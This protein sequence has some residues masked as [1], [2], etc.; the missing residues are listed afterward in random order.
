MEQTVPSDTPDEESNP[1]EHSP[2]N[3]KPKLWMVRSGAFDCAEEEDLGGGRSLQLKKYFSNGNRGVIFTA[4]FVSGGV[5]TP[6][7]VKEVL[8]ERLQKP[9]RSFVGSSALVSEGQWL[10]RLNL[11]GIGPR[12]LHADTTRVVMEFVS[13]KRILSFL[14]EETNADV[15]LGTLEKVMLQLR[16]LDAMGVHKGELVKPDRHIIVKSDGDPVLIDFE[17]CKDS[18]SPQNLT[19]FCQF[20]VSRQLANALSGP[21]KHLELDIETVRGLCKT[22]KQNGFKD[23]DFNA[24][25]LYVRD[26]RK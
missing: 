4:L 13:G 9:G 15:C 5:S 11:H 2:P 14:L 12:L 6:A 24:L 18:S 26:A 22:Y 21:G 16:K 20:L 10:A 25:I 1:S 8:H 7:A 3:A 17:R 19:Q 23:D